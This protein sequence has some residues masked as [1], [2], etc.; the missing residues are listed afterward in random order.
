M[1]LTH[2]QINLFIEYYIIIM[3]VPPEPVSESTSG[4]FE[5]SVF[6]PV[7]DGAVLSPKMNH[8]RYGG[9]RNDAE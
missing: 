6:A 1:M 3:E 2:A 4:F 9:A 7:V 8:Y 5:E